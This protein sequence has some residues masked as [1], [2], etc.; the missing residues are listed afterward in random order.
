MSSTKH[1]LC[2]LE[3]VCPEL[4]LSLVS[5]CSLKVSSVKSFPFDVSRS[6]QLFESFV[7]AGAWITR[8]NGVRLSIRLLGQDSCVSPADGF[9]SMELQATIIRHLEVAILSVSFPALC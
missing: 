1:E 9:A 5:T 2:R 6:D 3:H 4:D 8:S 7:T